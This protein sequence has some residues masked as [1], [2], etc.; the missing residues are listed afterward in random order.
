ME[1]DLIFEL[2]LHLDVDNH[3][4]LLREFNGISN[5]IYNDLAQAAG[6]ADDGIG[7]VG[8]HVVGE[9]QSFLVSTKAEWLQ[10][11]TQAVAQIEI[12]RFDIQLSC[13]DLGIIQNV[14]D[15]GKQGI[16]G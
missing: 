11:V 10:G 12:D 4:S 9:L 16:C 13:F 6:V 5:Q 7:N 15:Q 2:R 1:L 14:V 8:L 3:F